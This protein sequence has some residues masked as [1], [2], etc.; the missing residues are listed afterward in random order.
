MP[1]QR[2]L[3]NERRFSR[4]ALAAMVCG[5]AVCLA[6]SGC[7][8]CR[9]DPAT[10]EKDEKPKKKPKPDYE[11]GRLEV[12]PSDDALMRNFVKPGHVA[13]ASFRAV[14]NNFDMRAELKTE[15]TAVDQTVVPVGDTRFHMLASRP[16]LLPKGQPKVFESTYF[17]P[18][19][20]GK[21][22]ST[23]FLHHM[24]NSARGGSLVYEN[25]EPTRQMPPHQYLFVVLAANPNAYGYVKA[26]HSVVPS[27]D[28]LL[29][30]AGEVVYY[31]AVLPKIGDRAPVPSSLNAWT[32]IAYVL[33]DG[34]PVDKLTRDQQRAMIDW[35]HWGG[36]L[37]V[38]GPDSLEQL[39][40]SFL[41][42]YLPAT[43]GGTEELKSTHFEPLNANW[44]LTKKKSGERLSLKVLDTSPLVGV[45]LRLEE[46]ARWLEG[47]GELV[48]ERQVGRGRTVVTSFALRNS[49]IVN[50][51]SFDSFV[52]GALLRRPPRVFSVTDL[53]APRTEWKGMSER[54]LDPRLTSA[55]RF[56]ARDVAPGGEAVELTS[57]AAYAPWSDDGCAPHT[58]GGVASWNDRSGSSL[59][60][61]AALRK[62]AGISIPKARFVFSVLAVY[63]LILVPV[64]W[65]VFRL[66][67]R[68]EWAW[69]AAPVIALIGAV[70]V[71]RLAQLDIGFVRSRTEIGVLEIQ[72]ER[73]QAHLT[74][75]TAL[76]SSLSTA[77]QFQFDDVAAVAR[78]FIPTPSPDTLWPIESTREDGTRVSGFQVDS[79]TTGFIHSEQMCELEGAVR[80]KGATASEWQI[81]NSSGLNLRQ[82]RV[83][84]RD[85]DGTLTEG[86]LAELAAGGSGRVP[87]RPFAPVE[88]GG[89]VSQSAGQSTGQSAGESAGDVAKEM[90]EEGDVRDLANQA[91]RRMALRPGDVRLVAW[92]DDPLP[93]LEIAPAASQVVTRT[94]VL[95]HL[96]YGPLPPPQPDHNLL[97]DVYDAATSGPRPNES[98][99]VESFDPQEKTTPQ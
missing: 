88:Q 50:W 89:K 22:N 7:S 85:A 33:W 27:V 18:N 44:A 77:Y 47:T 16:A 21:E 49:E 48:A 19:D 62:A 31:R 53:G 57:S 51:G 96:R 17:I 11:I 86:T 72:G 95:V 55:T 10:E 52:N 76:Y 66:M 34:M 73:P 25:T 65:T 94:V 37:I 80:L 98:F 29:D 35:L 24:L 3:H 26:L 54:R 87:R 64:N 6:L 13:T 43:S 84:A 38:S 68:V 99:E 1:M 4:I 5:V 39:A 74:R 41:A 69:V 81:E 12:M 60:A 82:V 58:T 23:L 15:V 63:L 42:P 46:Q 79:S 92:T 20:V 2:A 14:A 9:R 56:F 67:G 97:S 70:A 91:L 61:H 93:G 90:T 83:L 36:Q 30:D 8:G 71:I 45:R 32:A 59:L 78:P 75:Y 28:D 40:G